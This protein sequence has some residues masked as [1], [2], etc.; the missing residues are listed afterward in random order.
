MELFYKKKHQILK[1]KL[2]DGT[3]KTILADMTSSVADLLQFIGKKIHIS[4]ADEYGLQ[5]E[6]NEGI[7]SP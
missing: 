4:S 1:I 6:V 5:A 2:M 7:L 3:I